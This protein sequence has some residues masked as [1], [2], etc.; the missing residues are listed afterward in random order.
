MNRSK[1]TF[2]FIADK[3]IKIN[4]LINNNIIKTECENERI[5]RM[6]NN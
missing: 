6:F 3:E 1:Q 2:F 5:Q 4:N